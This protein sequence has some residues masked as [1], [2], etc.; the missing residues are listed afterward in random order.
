M[1][2]LHPH[3]VYLRTILLPLKKG[4]EEGKHEDQSPLFLLTEASVCLRIST[5]LSLLSGP[6]LPKLSA[7]GTEIWGIFIIK[8]LSISVV[9]IHLGERLLPFTVFFFFNP[10][11]LPV[12]CPLRELGEVVI[13]MVG[14]YFDGIP[15][16]VIY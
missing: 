6:F 14:D 15:A 1:F 4:E 2:T 10:P 9:S 11:F 5:P 7:D 3:P 12:A 8:I 16:C 13:L